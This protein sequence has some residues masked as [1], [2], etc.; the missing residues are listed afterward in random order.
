MGSRRRRQPGPARLHPSRRFCLMSGGF[1][2]TA[3]RGDRAEDS[4]LVVRRAPLFLSPRHGLT[5][6]PQGNRR[7]LHRQRGHLTIELRPRFQ[8]P[9]PTQVAWIATDEERRRG[10]AGG[11]PGPQR[12]CEIGDMIEDK[13]ASL[14][15]TPEQREKINQE[16]FGIPE[17]DGGLMQPCC[18]P[19]QRRLQQGRMDVLVIFAGNSQGEPGF[20]FG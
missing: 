13:A 12:R 15:T 14:D 2:Q 4:V 18:K 16:R 11:N 19:L 8:D 6:L 9:N 17:G 10:L 1:C 20:Q 5:V 7:V 3:H